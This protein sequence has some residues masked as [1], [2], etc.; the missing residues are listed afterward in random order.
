M[1]G[2]ERCQRP[3]KLASQG[4]LHRQHAHILLQDKALPTWRRFAGDPILPLGRSGCCDRPGGVVLKQR[5]CP[6]CGNSS[7]DAAAGCPCGFLWHEGVEVPAP[8]IVRAGAGQRS[9]TQQLEE[10]KPSPKQDSGTSPRWSRL[11]SG[12]ASSS[13]SVWPVVPGTPAIAGYR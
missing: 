5:I 11:W 6:N 9:A 4:V 2:I 8:D 3:G 10:T 12:W 1:V 7:P 13:P